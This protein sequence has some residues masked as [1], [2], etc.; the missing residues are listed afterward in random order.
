MA[1]QLELSCRASQGHHGHFIVFLVP[2]VLL[3]K[4]ARASL[5]LP[6]ASRRACCLH[7]GDRTC[8]LVQ[9]R[10]ISSL[11]GR[12]NNKSQ[13]ALAE[14]PGNCGTEQP[15]RTLRLLLACT[16]CIWHSFFLW[17]V[18]LSINFCTMECKVHFF[19]LPEQLWHQMNMNC[20]GKFDNLTVTFCFQSDGC[21]YVCK[22]LKK[23]LSFVRSAGEYPVM[24]RCLFFFNSRCEACVPSYTIDLFGIAFLL[25]YFFPG[26]VFSGCLLG[27]ALG[28]CLQHLA[29]L[30]RNWFYRD[31]TSGAAPTIS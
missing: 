23:P 17:S 26:S 18:S 7:L 19:L 31:S 29:S 15:H 16:S 5:E 12:A 3:Q 1:W 13:L 21:L 14:R 6:A 27:S 20:C 22:F 2:R 9:W 8:L 10:W 30:T 28:L 11:R 24:I 25:V 4:G